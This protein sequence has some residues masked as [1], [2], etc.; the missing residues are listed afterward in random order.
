MSKASY[1][2]RKIM[3][4]IV[5]A[6][7]LT[8]T[9]SFT[10]PAL[11]QEVTLTIIAASGW[12][13]CEVGK[14]LTPEFT[15]YAEEKLGYPV[16]IVWDLVP[17]ANWYE[18]AAMALASH[19]TQYDI[20]FSDSQWLGT[21]SY[22]KH[23]VKLN[24]FIEKDPEL[25]A[26][27]EDFYQEHRD[28]YMSYPYG[29][30]NYWGLPMEGDDLVLYVRS[31]LLNDSTE[32]A[33]FKAK[34]GFDLPR[35]YEDFDALD[36]FKFEK[37]LEFFTRPPDLYG[38]AMEYS[39]EY[40]FISDHVM[41]LFWSWGGDIINWET[42]KV[43]GIM[44]SPQNVEALEYYKHL[45]KYQPLGAA[46]Y[47]IDQ[48]ITAISQ[49]KV[50][51][52]LTW[53]AVGFPI[54][55]PKTSLVSDKV[56]VVKPPK[57]KVMRSYC[58]GGQPWVVSEYSQHKKEVF[59]FFKWWYSKEIQ[60]KFAEMGGNP[61]I[62]KLIDSEEF[63]KLNPWNRAYVEMIPGARDFWHLPCYAEMLLVQQEEW[64]NYVSGATP[65]AKT[66]LDR[67]ASRQEE[68]LKD[69]EFLK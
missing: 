15:K 35:T 2:I 11:A 26:I 64:H 47:G 68:I 13:P 23:I 32:R 30:P 46:D 28:A 19:S 52:T 65:D 22:G 31:D 48:C 43:D 69:W 9:A 63:K 61:V 14:K 37:V 1:R 45:L 51:S 8:T 67:T 49:G 10:T 53:A 24:D 60:W 59:E 3:V 7:V 56:L 12:T 20:I 36:W 4:G 58:I 18:K 39:K 17:F 55:D 5:V 41:A 50:F 29:T 38:T 33:N 62:R 34:Y 66:A 57:G 42:Y 27:V 25:K 16:K 54:F 40:D 6:I 21:F 44:N